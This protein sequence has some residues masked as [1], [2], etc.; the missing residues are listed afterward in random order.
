MYQSNR[1]IYSQIFLIESYKIFF[2]KLFMHN[3][4]ESNICVLKINK[5]KHSILYK[6]FFYFKLLLI[7]SFIIL[8]LK[9]LIWRIYSCLAWMCIWWQF[10]LRSNTSDTNQIK[11]IFEFIFQNAA[12]YNFA[13]VTG[14]IIF[15]PFDVRLKNVS[16]YLICTLTCLF[17]S[18]YAYE[19]YEI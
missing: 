12:G 18:S 2:W 17:Q 19:K 6:K 14:H 3:K 8:Y 16:M 11:I 1:F 4:L 7:R 10:W 5:I 15:C 13:H 9:N